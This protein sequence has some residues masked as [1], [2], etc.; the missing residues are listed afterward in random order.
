MDR[1]AHRQSGAGNHQWFSKSAH[2]KRKWESPE[3]T[4]RSLL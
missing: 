3:K 1:D 2:V 4:L